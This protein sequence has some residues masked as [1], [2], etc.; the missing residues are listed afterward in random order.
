MEMIK[1]NFAMR[2][3]CDDID[4]KYKFIYNRIFCEVNCIQYA[5]CIYEKCKIISNLNPYLQ[6]NLKI[7]IDKKI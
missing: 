5:S 3:Q 4:L 2:E 1:N 6:V 7:F